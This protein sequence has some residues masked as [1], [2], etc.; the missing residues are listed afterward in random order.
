MKLVNTFPEA[1][2]TSVTGVRETT[3]VYLVVVLAVANVLKEGPSTQQTQYH[4]ITWT[5][6]TTITEQHCYSAI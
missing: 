4:F 3:Q 6:N 2:P 1:T 5:K